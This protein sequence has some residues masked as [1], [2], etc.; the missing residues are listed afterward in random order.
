[1]RKHN[2][3][4]P[5]DIAILLKIVSLKKEGW[6]LL[7]LSAATKI[8]LSEISESL[9]RS[10][11]AGLIDFKKKKVN[12]QNLLEFLEHGIKYVF[13][14]H[15]GTMTR[16]IPTAHCHP[17]MKRKFI[18]DINYVWPDPNGNEL[19]LVIEPFYKHQPEA[20][21]AHPEFYKLLALVDVIRVGKLREIEF[22]IKELKRILSNE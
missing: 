15:P 22:A 11:Q 20:I 9:N 4:R 10:W 13:P 1:M 8:S 17:F 18:S 7:A 21:K 12:N 5:Q 16:G 3:M 6:N 2:G 14:Q 19:G